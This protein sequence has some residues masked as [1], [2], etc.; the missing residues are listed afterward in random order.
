[1]NAYDYKDEILEK[2]KVFNPVFHPQNED[3]C[4]IEIKNKSSDS[5]FIYLEDEI[6]IEFKDWHAHYSDYD[7]AIENVDNFLNNRECLISIYSNDKYYFCGSTFNKDDYSKD[8]VVDFIK[9]FHLYSLV[10][11]FKEYGV[12]AKLEYFDST[13]DKEIVVEKERF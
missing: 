13:K 12:V 8:E 5:L 11:I 3:S 4:S 6:T 9:D 10:Q 1:M 7:D 2:Y